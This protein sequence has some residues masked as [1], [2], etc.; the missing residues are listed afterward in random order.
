M[1]AGPPQLGILGPPKVGVLSPVLGVLT[2]NS[3]TE[4]LDD[5]GLPVVA[6]SSSKI[7]EH[8]VNDVDDDDADNLR[9]TP[10]NPPASAHNFSGEATT[11]E[12]TLLTSTTVLR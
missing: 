4:L 7:M 1:L 12:H 2:G 5:L 9:N 3:V 10:R 11:T 6:D 8:A